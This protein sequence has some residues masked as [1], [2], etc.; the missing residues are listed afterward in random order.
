VL[1]DT[2]GPTGRFEWDDMQAKGI[3]QR[4]SEEHSSCLTE[5]GRWVHGCVGSG[6]QLALL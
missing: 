1:V 5:R 4:V 3:G 2:P 6:P